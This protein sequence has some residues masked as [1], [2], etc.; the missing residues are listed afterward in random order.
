MRPRLELAAACIAARKETV[1]LEGHHD[2]RGS[3]EYNLML[4][5][6]LARTVRRALERLD[7][8]GERMRTV[9]YGE[10]RPACPGHDEPCWALCRRVEIRFAP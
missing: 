7:V 10:G 1:V 8:D 5:E 9:S 6:R 4:G 2:E 3:D